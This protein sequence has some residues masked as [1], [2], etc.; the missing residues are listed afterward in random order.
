MVIRRWLCGANGGFHHH[1]DWT[2][3]SE[4]LYLESSQLTETRKVP[5]FCQSLAVVE[6]TGGWQWHCRQCCFTRSNVWSW[7]SQLGRDDNVDGEEA[8]HVTTPIEGK[9][10]RFLRA[11]FV[12]GRSCRSTSLAFVILSLL[13]LAYDSTDLSHMC[14]VIWNLLNQPFLVVTGFDISR[15]W[16]FDISTTVSMNRI[17]T[18]LTFQ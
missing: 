4:T 11:W 17:W 6:Y 10:E 18:A 8:T 2:S 7:S 5:S 15:L 1:L 16:D 9:T 12:R 3:E 13:S 14:F